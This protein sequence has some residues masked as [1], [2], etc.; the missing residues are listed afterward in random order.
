VTQPATLRLAPSL[1][2][3]LN[4]VTRKH[5]FLGTTGSGKTYGATKLAEL[6]IAAGA[7]IV[8][9][10]PVG[11]WWSL[12]LAADGESQGIKIP[13]FDGR[14]ADLREK[15]LIEVVGPGEIALT[16]AG[17]ALA[18]ASQAI[19]SLSELHATWL[20]KLP[21]GE[22]EALRILLSVHPQ[23]LHRQSLAHAMSRQD[24]WRFSAL[25]NQLKSLGVADFNGSGEIALTDALFP[26]GLS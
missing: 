4:A 1:V 25:L 12:R 20:T 17:R 19:R 6:M 16:S 26:A 15:G 21:A 13:V 14:I 22:S 10:D 3:P 24:N 18:D 23:R 7:Q 5:A 2:L 9:L 8:A 11:V